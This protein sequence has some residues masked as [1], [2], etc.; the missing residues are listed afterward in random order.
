MKSI[1][2]A[3]EAIIELENAYTD[4]KLD[5]VINL[6]D[7]ILEAELI[8]KNNSI[9]FTKE[10][11]IETA[12]LLKLSLINNLQKN[13]FPSFKDVEREFSELKEVDEN[14]YCITEK[15]FYTN[16]EKYINNVFLSN[17]NDSWKIITVEEL[18]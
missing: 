6:K 13:G 18:S 3:I 16:G 7:F 10:I 4:N 12:E 8:I 9:P 11:V 17:K 15:L 1:K 14:I 2:T 5:A